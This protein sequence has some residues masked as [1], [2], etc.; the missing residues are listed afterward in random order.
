M[1]MSAGG[2]YIDSYRDQWRHLYQ[3]VRNAEPAACTLQD[4]LRVV[5]IT[6]AVLQSVRTGA[7][8]RLIS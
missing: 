6:T 5:E 7:P 1:R 8:V 4:G 2:D 3:M